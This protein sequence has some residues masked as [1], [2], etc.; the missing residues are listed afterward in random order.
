MIKNYIEYHRL[1]LRLPRQRGTP[2]KKIGKKIPK[3]D[4]EKIFE[5]LLEGIDYIYLG[6]RLAY[7]LGLRKAEIY[8]LKKSDLNFKRWIEDAEHDKETAPLEVK[9]SGKGNKERIGV[10]TDQIL[11]HLL[12]T[13][14]I[15]KMPNE[16]LIASTYSGNLLYKHFINAC[17][18]AGLTE[19]RDGKT[20]AKY[21]LHD[22]RRT[23][24]TEWY[25]KSKDI[26]DTRNR[27][28][29]AYITT[30]QLYIADDQ[31]TTINKWREE[32]LLNK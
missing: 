6:I 16:R 23:R 25:N 22:L 2:K 17:K 19:E 11:I 12:L 13:Y 29:H 4:L 10:I 21:T 31:E 15:K 27:L 9:I 5:Q 1:N 3:K 32:M 30:T 26:N 14:F 8:N 20:M 18:K 28:G 24:G 7:E